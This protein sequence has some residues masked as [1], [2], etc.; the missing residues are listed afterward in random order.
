MK[1]RQPKIWNRL[2]EENTRWYE[3]FELYRLMGPDRAVL[4]AYNTWR[5]QNGKLPANNQPRSWSIKSKEHRW[6]ERADAWDE[7]NREEKRQAV[8]KEAKQF[9]ELH[10]QA[11]RAAYSKL[12]QRLQK[13]DPDEYDA[14]K[15]TGQL[16]QIGRELRTIYDVAPPDRIE[17]SGPE[18][19][20]IAIDLELRRIISQRA[21]QIRDEIDQKEP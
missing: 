13:I 18:G 19:R 7:E 20:P 5:V 21:E 3:R 16:I 8:A 6:I 14:D 2:P 4:K 11:L 10:I 1:A 15:L 12:G 9:Q 17:L